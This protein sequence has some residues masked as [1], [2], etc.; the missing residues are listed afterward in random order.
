[1]CASDR[2]RLEIHSLAQL[3]ESKLFQ[4]M[5]QLDPDLRLIV[6][7]ANILRSSTQ[8]L[9]NEH[10]V[11]E[12]QVPQV[13]DKPRIFT[14]YDNEKEGNGDGNICDVGDNTCFNCDSSE[15]EEELERLKLTRSPCR[16]R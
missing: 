15:C 5:S 14:T 3:A 10:L 8:A 7:H 16:Y 4:E 6:G 9:V 1:M 13:S 2:T 11:Q 12:I